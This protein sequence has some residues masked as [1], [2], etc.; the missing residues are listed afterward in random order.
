MVGDGLGKLAVFHARIGHQRISG[1]GDT[2]GSMKYRIAQNLGVTEEELYEEFFGLNHLSW[3]NSVQVNGEKIMPRLITDDEFLSS[4]QELE[5]FDP[6]IIRATGMLPNEYLY[7]YYH[8]ERA[9]SNINKSDK[10]RGQTIEEGN[11]R[12][13]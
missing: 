9:Q 8:R 12:M 10:T 6:G 1:I 4:I 3:I 7:Y 5:I 13:M 11:I 2:P